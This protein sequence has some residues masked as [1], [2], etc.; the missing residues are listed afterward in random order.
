MKILQQFTRAKRLCPQCQQKSLLLNDVMHANAKEPLVCAQC[1]FK[2]YTPG[3]VRF[4]ADIAG[5]ILA[6]GSLLIVL[7]V[8]GMGMHFHWSFSTGFVVFIIL[9]VFYCFLGYLSLLF[10]SIWL[11]LIPA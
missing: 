11:P 3:V 5:E 6:Y 1:G 2:C 9:E 7:I 10:V 4:L 8:I